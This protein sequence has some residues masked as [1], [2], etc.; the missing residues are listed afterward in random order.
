M[1]GNRATHRRWCRL[2]RRC[3]AFDVGQEE[4]HRADRERELPA[5]ARHGCRPAHRRLGPPQRSQPARRDRSLQH[6]A[7]L[8]ATIND[9]RAREP[10]PLG[11]PSQGT[12]VSHKYDHKSGGTS[13]SESCRIADAWE[14]HSRRC[15]L[16]KSHCA[17]FGCTR[18]GRLRSVYTPISRRRVVGV[19]HLPSRSGRLLARRQCNLS[20]SI[21]EPPHSRR[22]LRGSPA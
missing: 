4:G 7:R 21:L 18:R 12:G 20:R 13:P 6:I 3:R 2:P 10:P 11:G 15:V 19:V 17:H 22:A 8:T 16:R 5:A 9:R 1:P 14:D